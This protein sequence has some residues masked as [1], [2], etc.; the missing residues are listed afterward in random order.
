[1][2]SKPKVIIVTGGAGFIGSHFVRYLINHTKNKVINLDKLTYSGSKNNIKDIYSSKRHHF[3]K[4]DIS[5]EKTIKFILNKFKPNFV[6]NFAAET[7]VDNSIKNSYPF[8]KTNIIGTYNLLN[9]SKIYWESLEIKKKKQFRFLQV[10]T[11][12]VFG[13]LKRTDQ[14]FTENT[15]YDPSSPYSASKASADHIV[16]AFHRTYKFPINI[17]N[18]SNNYGPNQHKEKLIPLIINNILHHQKLPVYGKGLQIRDW[19]YV[20]DHVEAIW[21]IIL[22]GKIGETYLIGGNNE[23]KNIFIVNL[24]CDLLD[25]A[26]PS[27][28]NNITSYKS[29]IKFVKDRPG[30]DFRYAINARK[31]FKEIKWK[32]R[33]SFEE[34]IKKTVNWYLKN[35]LKK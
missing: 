8:I 14:S 11:D 9:L 29:L 31:I 16:R 27:K 15:R 30:H 17:T 23:K 33:H 21:R 25:Q 4:G 28:K 18:C 32:P 12:E 3:I 6:V 13:D 34:G 20:E 1:M 35:F 5:N 22:K 26:Y 2:P 7:H 19:L 24:I 10:S